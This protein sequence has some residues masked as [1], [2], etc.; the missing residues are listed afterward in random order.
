MGPPGRLH[1]G[2]SRNEPECRLRH[3]GP[4]GIYTQVRK[5]EDG[6]SGFGPQQGRGAQLSTIPEAGPAVPF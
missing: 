3:T 4:A 2:G 1:R 5:R 6:G